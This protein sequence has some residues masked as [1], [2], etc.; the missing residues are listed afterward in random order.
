MSS[1]NP[2]TRKYQLSKEEIDQGFV[3]LDFYDICELIGGMRSAQSHAA[4]KVLFM[5]VRGHKNAIKDCSEAIRS[6]EKEK[7]QR[8]KL[9]RIEKQ[10]HTPIVSDID[11]I[12]EQKKNAG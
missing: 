5:G 2:Y 10:R 12:L 4:K 11:S 1:N 7:A 8:E 3:E 9:E 6:L